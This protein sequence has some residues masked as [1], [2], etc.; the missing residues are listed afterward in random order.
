[1][2]GV[3]E[4]TATKLLRLCPDRRFPYGRPRLRHWDWVASDASDQAFRSGRIAMAKIFGNC[5]R[6]RRQMGARFGSWTSPSTRPQ[7][8]AGSH[9][10]QPTC[11]CR[12]SR[13]RAG[14]R[15]TQGVGVG[16]RPKAINVAT[17]NPP[18]MGAQAVRE[19]AVSSKFFGTYGMRTGCQ[20]KDQ[21]LAG[22]ASPHG[23]PRLLGLSSYGR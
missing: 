13:R 3:P 5:F 1:M 14:S 15:A 7:L 20:A 6:L 12:R 22:R 8:G 17:L 11:A 18:H 10:G 4:G 19:P 21:P 16:R 9:L 2:A 23:G